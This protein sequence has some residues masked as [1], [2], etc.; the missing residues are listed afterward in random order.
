MAGPAVG[1][2]EKLSLYPWDAEIKPA[3]RDK[4]ESFM[5]RVQSVAVA[6][7][8]EVVGEC[9]VGEGVRDDEKWRTA[10]ML[11]PTSSKGDVTS[12]TWSRG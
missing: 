9:C 3:A 4:Q 5:V 11:I 7:S 10:F 6:G 2:V 8:C 12:F 1:A